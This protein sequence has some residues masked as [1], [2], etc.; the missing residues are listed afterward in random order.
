MFNIKSLIH[1]I[2]KDELI[3]FDAGSSLTK[4]VHLKSLASNK[5]SLEKA[6]TFDFGYGEEDQITMDEFAEEMNKQG[7]VGASVSASIEDTSLRI[8]RMNLPKMPERDLKEAIRWN[9]RE[10]I[11][12]PIDEYE[13]A[14]TDLEPFNK[15]DRMPLVAYGISETS[16]E[17]AKLWYKQVGL[18][19]MSLEAAVV[20]LHAAF[21][22]NIGWK[23]GK[24]SAMLNLGRKV[25]NFVVL[26]KS[27][28]LFSRPL[29]AV[30][31][32]C[33]IQSISQQLNIT[34]TE[35]HSMLRDFVDQKLKFAGED[36]IKFE[37]IISDFMSELVIEIQRSIDAFCIMFDIDALDNMYLCG[38]GAT[39]PNLGEH[40][41][42]S[43]G[44]QTEVFNSFARIHT[45]QLGDPDLEKRAPLFAIA[46]GLALPRL[47]KRRI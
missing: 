45:R 46:L 11:D 29:A 23:E 18:R 31:E 7:L 44:I 35:A 34:K 13:V 41:S 12:C 39:L 4:V 37:K 36:K 21:D 8:R 47:K 16:V 15:G 26:G 1:L 43:L 28:L 19:V 40:L 14:Y 9:F 30:N 32:D 10:H 17:K 3:G 25:S 27:R 6:L 24:I 2:K 42:K 38:G 5:F 20:A 33:V 22:Y